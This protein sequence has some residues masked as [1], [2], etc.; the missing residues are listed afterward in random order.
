MPLV[1][2]QSDAHDSPEHVVGTLEI[3]VKLKCSLLSSK[4][5]CFVVRHVEL[6]PIKFLVTL[7]MLSTLYHLLSFEIQSACQRHKPLSPQV[8]VLWVSLGCVLVQLDHGLV[9]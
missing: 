7:T 4:R 9:Y 6:A 8:L 5:E 2:L 3:L 1:Y